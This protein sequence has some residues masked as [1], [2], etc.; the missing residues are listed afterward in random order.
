MIPELYEGAPGIGKTA[1][2]FAEGRTS[3]LPVIQINL[4][5]RDRIEICGGMVPNHDRKVL[6]YYA[7]DWWVTACEAPAIILLDELTTA[8]D[9]QRT[10]AL[11][12]ADDSR[13]LGAYTL[14]EETRIRAT[15]NPAEYAAGARS[16]LNAPELGGRWRIIQVD[17]TD[18]VRWMCG[19]EGR[20]GEFGRFCRSIPT[21]ALATP[22]AM[23]RAMA[24]QRPFPTPRG[25]TR[26]VELNDED[27][28]QIVG[29]PAAATYLQWKANV[30]LPDPVEILAGRTMEVP[31]TSDQ[32]LAVATGLVSLVMSNGDH[33]WSL[34]NLFKWFKA[35]AE[36]G[37]GGVVAGELTL[38]VATHMDAVTEAMAEGGPLEHYAALVLT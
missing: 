28:H 16:L 17:Q 32:A 20:L 37:F 23:K 4:A 35:A 8:D 6:E 19:H 14:H 27:L 7:P 11:R 21:A 10:A 34:K 5:D 13:I 38:M 33:K 30:S 29:A 3:G 24:D 18:A 25:W 26:A 9:D 12:V 1:R 36:R 31:P 15:M 22:E 2:V